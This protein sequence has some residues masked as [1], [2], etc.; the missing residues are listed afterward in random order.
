ML[1]IQICIQPKEQ[2]ET[3]GTPWETQNKNDELKIK[4]IP[5]NKTKIK[6]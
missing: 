4:Q 1:L 2:R 6:T 5:W 3:F